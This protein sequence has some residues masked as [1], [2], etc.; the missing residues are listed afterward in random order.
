MCF[1]CFSKDMSK[2]GRQVAAQLP[3]NRPSHMFLQFPDDLPNQSSFVSR[4]I[5]LLSK[6]ISIPHDLSWRVADEFGCNIL[7]F[8]EF[9][10]LP[11]GY[12]YL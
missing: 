7:F 12:D 6:K 3:P 5:G 8:K 11:L 10:F 2:R 4:L 9:T 1:V